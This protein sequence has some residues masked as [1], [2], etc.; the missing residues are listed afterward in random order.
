MNKAT[1]HYWS[2]RKGHQIIG[3]TFDACAYCAECGEGLPETDTEGNPKH[4][5]FATDQSNH[6][7][8]WRCDTCGLSIEEW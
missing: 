6:L 4:P 1:R 3:Y 8:E 2:L 7:T 5:V